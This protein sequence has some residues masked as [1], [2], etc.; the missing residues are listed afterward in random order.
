MPRW[1]GE[2][3]ADIWHEHMLVLHDAPWMHISP[4]SR[5][6]VEQLYVNELSA[7]ITGTSNI[8]NEPW[9]G[10]LMGFQLDSIKEEAGL[11][12]HQGYF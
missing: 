2:W 10:P 4:L 9:I 6:W 3:F 5:N 12:V 1:I 7:A 8:P 11:G